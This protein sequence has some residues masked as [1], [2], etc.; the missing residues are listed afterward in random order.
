MIHTIGID[1]DLRPADREALLAGL[2][3][4]FGEAEEHP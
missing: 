1:A 4:T 2:R 3:A